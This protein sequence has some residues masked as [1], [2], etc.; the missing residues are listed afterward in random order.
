M[1]S[2]M[3]ELA[4]SMIF[5]Y[6]MLSAASSAIQEIIANIFRWRAKTLEKGI[7]G[8]FNKDFKDKFYKLPLIE[9]LCSPNARGQLSHRPSYTPSGTFGL[10]VLVFPRVPISCAKDAYA[11]GH[12]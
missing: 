10:A 5:L 11:S 12:S 6:L 2:T 7:E 1:S 9:S 4:I 3:L 8:L